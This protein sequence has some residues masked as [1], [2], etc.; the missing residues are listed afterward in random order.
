MAL[1]FVSV[2]SFHSLI[3]DQLQFEIDTSNKVEG[4]NLLTFRS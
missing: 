4:H 3:F 1:P 2:D